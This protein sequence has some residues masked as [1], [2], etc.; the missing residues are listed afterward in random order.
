MLNRVFVSLC[1]A[2]QTV[3]SG[4]SGLLSPTWLDYINDC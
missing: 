4:N 1:V 3:Q 2:A